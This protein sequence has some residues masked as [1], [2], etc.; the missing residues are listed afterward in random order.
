M[1]V[2]LWKESEMS[3]IECYCMVHRL[4]ETARLLK[5]VFS[6][7]TTRMQDVANELQT[8]TSSHI[9]PYTVS[10]LIGTKGAFHQTLTGQFDENLVNCISPTYI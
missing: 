10:N 5:N 9:A 3:T 4:T 6:R 7:S 2:C 1:I 8:R